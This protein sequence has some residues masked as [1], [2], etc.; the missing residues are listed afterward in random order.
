MIKDHAVRSATATNPVFPYPRKTLV[1]GLLRAILR[2]LLPV[3]TRLDIQNREGLPKRGPVILSGNH[4]GILEAVLMAAYAPRQ[5]EFLGTGDIPL[6]PRY[7]WITRG[8][9]LIPIN[10]GNLDREGIQKSVDVLKQGGIL[11]IFPEGGIWSPA[12]MAPQ[13]GVALISQRAQAPILPIGF[14][15]LK[16]AL[17][18]LFKLQRPRVEIRVG[19]P[20]PPVPYDQPA[21]GLKT[22]LT[23]KAEEVLRAIRQLMPEAERTERHVS[24]AYTLSAETRP[25]VQD[26]QSERHSIPGGEVFARFLLNPVLVDA[27]FRNVGLK[28][29]PLRGQ[30]G[31]TSNGE[32]R[33]ALAEI[34]AYLQQNPGFFTYRFGMA[35]GV[36]M[37]EA[38]EALEAQLT[39][40]QA[41]G[42]EFWLEAQVEVAY[43]DG[44]LERRAQKYRI[45]PG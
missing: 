8:Y 34:K 22:A 26:G 23:A 11:G 3:L 37:P 27:L 5:V 10:R 24:E 14:G 32:F 33:S 15:G 9:G 36:R 18:R 43:A 12:N 7:A 13:L 2:M 35:L 41:Q 30:A 38:L 40:A 19:E 28:I 42:A 4:S 17:P 29:D 20:I 31:P 25:M 45:V 21:G 6:D 44:R 39:R 1:R 16:N